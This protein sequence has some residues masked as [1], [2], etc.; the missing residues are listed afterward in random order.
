[1]S[2]TALTAHPSPYSEHV[3][4]RF[5]VSG[6]SVRQEFPHRQRDWLSVRFQREVSGIVKTDIS[7]WNVSLECVRAGGQKERIVF[8]PHG[9]EK[10]GEAD[11]PS[12]TVEGAALSECW[13]SADK[14]F[15]SEPNQER[16]QET[17]LEMPRW[18]SYP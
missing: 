8:A 12:T 17:E 10:R 6:S 3:L 14:K 7:T 9:K 18:A 1:M 16:W 11:C 13:G 4:G 2:D 15:Q 5:E